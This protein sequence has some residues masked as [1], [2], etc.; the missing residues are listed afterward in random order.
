MISGV[1]LRMHYGFHQGLTGSIVGGLFGTIFGLARYYQL[2]LTGT[3]YEEQRH[4]QMSQK[5]ILRE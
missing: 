4:D 5:I 1:L 3:T 2:K